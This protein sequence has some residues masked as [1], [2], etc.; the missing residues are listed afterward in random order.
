MRNVSENIIEEIKTSILS[1]RFFEKHAFL[2][3][4]VEKYF[5]AGQATGDNINI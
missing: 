5:R 1:F 4:N 2:R 3:E